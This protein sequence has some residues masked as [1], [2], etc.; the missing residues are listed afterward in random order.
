MLRRWHIAAVAASAALCQCRNRLRCL[1]GEAEPPASL[2]LTPQ[3][4]WLKHLWWQRNRLASCAGLALGKCQGA[5]LV[6]RLQGSHTYDLPF[7][8]TSPSHTRTTGMGSAG[9]CSLLS[10]AKGVGWMC[11]AASGGR[12]DRGEHASPRQ[13]TPPIPLPPPRPGDQHSGFQVDTS[14]VSAH[15]CQEP[16]TAMEA[17]LLGLGW[18]Q[19]CHT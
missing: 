17:I 10:W 4:L 14:T 8:I 19:L 15:W 12:E 13:K 5:A 2:R 11:T 18:H 6:Q 3:A 16:A 9:R 7:C 1:P